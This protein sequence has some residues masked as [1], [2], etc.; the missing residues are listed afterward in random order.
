[1]SFVF[2]P[3]PSLPPSLPPSL[4]SSVYHC[5]P[6]L[7]GVYIICDSMCVVVCV[8]CVCVYIDFVM[9]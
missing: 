9:G 6:H 4:I 5:L 3:L 8:S 7:C 1:M 2:L